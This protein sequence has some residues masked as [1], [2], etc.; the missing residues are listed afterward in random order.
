MFLLPE[1]EGDLNELW[2]LLKLNTRYNQLRLKRLLVLPLL[3]NKYFHR[4]FNF[5]SYFYFSSAFMSF[6][7]L[8]YLFPVFC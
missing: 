5:C 1:S 4:Y 6:I 2:Q 7:F 3:K 8:I